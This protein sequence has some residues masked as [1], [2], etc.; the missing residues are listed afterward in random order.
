MKQELIDNSASMT[1]LDNNLLLS[2]IMT[3][4]FGQMQDMTSSVQKEM[5]SLEDVNAMTYDP[6]T[7]VNADAYFKELLLQ[8]LEGAVAEMD[9]TESSSLLFEDTQ[10][11]DTADSEAA[12]P[13]AVSNREMKNGQTATGLDCSKCEKHFLSTATLEK[14]MAMHCEDRP[15]RCNLC[16]NGFKLKVHLKKHH[17]YRHSDEYPCECSICGKKF[18]D[19]SAVRL[20]ERIHSV[21]RPFECHCGKSFKTRENLWGH[22]NRGP[23]DKSQEF[24]TNNMQLFRSEEFGPIIG[25]PITSTAVLQHLSGF[26]QSIKHDYSTVKN[27]GDVG[28]DDKKSSNLFNFRLNQAQSIR[29]G[30]EVKLIN[31]VL[32][33]TQVLPVAGGVHKPTAEEIQSQYR[34]IKQKVLAVTLPTAI[35]SPI[36]RSPLKLEVPED[37]P[38]GGDTNLDIPVMLSEPIRT[39]QHNFPSSL[40]H[41]SFPS[42]Q[43]V[44]SRLSCNETVA[45]KS[46]LTVSA[47]CL[48]NKDVISNTVQQLPQNNKHVASQ[49]IVTM[50]KSGIRTVIPKK[51]KA[52]LI[53]SF[54]AK[55]TKAVQQAELEM[56]SVNSPR[57]LNV[58]QSKSKKES[59]TEKCP[60]AYK[61]LMA[62][63]NKSYVVI[64]E[65]AQLIETHSP[66][67]ERASPEF[68]D[69][70]L[71]GT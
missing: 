45:I 44:K 60:T 53:S 30:G 59:V 7:L 6:Q 22:K 2:N 20:H 46:N 35:V 68:H 38:S 1:P 3:I 70:I 41:G 24:V 36:H 5:S 62:M 13:A 39:T 54:K 66:S 71:D 64:P 23:C 61:F 17:L 8:K 11:T 28:N 48:T 51:V 9:S 15:Y 43:P 21:D 50:L 31:D 29:C 25:V 32:D 63:N 52:E 10:S 14:H 18:K 55:R 57:P 40:H 34:S 69:Y 49:L 65:I 37:V 58:E 16:D 67:T 56:E 4:N 42:I 19:S 33:I 27:G 47:K 12:S 26:F